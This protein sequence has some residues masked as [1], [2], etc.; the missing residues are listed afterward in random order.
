VRTAPRA[1]Y[2][3]A[4]FTAALLRKHFARPG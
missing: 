2:L 4:G 3:R 1:F